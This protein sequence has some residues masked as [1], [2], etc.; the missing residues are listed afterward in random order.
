MQRDEPEPAVGKC[1]GQ[2]V[3]GYGA[4]QARGVGEVAEHRQVF[5]ERI[6][7]TQSV[8]PS[9][10]GLLPARVNQI[11][12]GSLDGGAVF[13]DRRHPGATAVADILH[14]MPFTHVDAQPGRVAQQNVIELR[15]QHMVGMRSAAGIFAKEE[16]P[17]LGVRTPY[18]RAP[19]FAHEAGP[20]DRRHRTEGLEN[21]QGRREQRLPDVIAREALLLE[22]Q[23][24]QASLR[25][26][27][28]GAR[29][30]RP[31]T[32]NNDVDVRHVVALT[33]RR[34][35][36]RPAAHRQAARSPAVRRRRLTKRVRIGTTAWETR[37]R[38]LRRRSRRPP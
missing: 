13:I 29:A 18:E 19:R 22:Q 20:F 17:R 36:A 12:R 37:G 34:A 23:H 31:T 16:T 30:G 32:D 9:Q 6:E 27:A 8:A 28:C 33:S 14:A 7:L 15:A 1:R 21:G 11:R 10:Q 24:P 35:T 5:E 38:Y 26:K 25:E 2:D 4:V 3:P